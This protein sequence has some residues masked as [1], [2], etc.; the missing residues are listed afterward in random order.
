MAAYHYGDMRSLRKTTKTTASKLPVPVQLVERRIYM[1]RGQ[2]VMLDADLAE[3]YQ[4]PTKR[5]NE[6]V[7]RNLG[8]FP[9]D[10]MFRL[11]Q[12]EAENLRSQIAT[13]SWG[14]RRNLPY[15]F[16]EHGV[17][18]LSA[19]LASERAVKMSVLIIRAFVRMRELIANH[20]ELAMPRRKDRRHAEQAE[21]GDHDTR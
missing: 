20:K 9:K 4:V 12:A 6:Q 14:G 7:Q 3:L 1:I 21:L 17:A 8:R 16:T 5:V 18:M 11:K 15:A 2:K 13:S 10:F 19:V